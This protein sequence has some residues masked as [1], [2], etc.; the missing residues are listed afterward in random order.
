MKR[1]HESSCGQT[2]CIPSEPFASSPC[3]AHDCRQADYASDTIFRL[4]ACKLHAGSVQ[5]MRH[6]LKRCHLFSAGRACTCLSTCRPSPAW[7]GT[8]SVSRSAAICRDQLSSL[9]L[10]P[11]YNPDEAKML[12]LHTTPPGAVRQ[13]SRGLCAAAPCPSNDASQLSIMLSQQGM[14]HLQTL[15][16]VLLVSAAI[17]SAPGDPYVSVHIRDAGDWTNALY[18][19][20]SS[21]VKT[22][23]VSPQRHACVRSQHAVCAELSQESFQRFR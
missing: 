9:V 1:P 5:G 12:A 8:P 21:Y 22:V 3:Q 23:E 11:G 13:L 10:T 17:T 7:S 15:M 20:M 18:K 4:V 2:H 19:Y 16:A 6:G 14:M